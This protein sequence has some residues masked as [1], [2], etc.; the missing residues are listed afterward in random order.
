[1]L[2]L[3]F[4]NLSITAAVCLRPGAK[5]PPARDVVQSRPV[6]DQRPASPDGGKRVHD[7]FYPGTADEAR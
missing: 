6:R 3:R 2:V 1:L 5:V 7:A 4:Q